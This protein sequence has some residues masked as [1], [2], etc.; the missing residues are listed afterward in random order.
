MSNLDDFLDAVEPDARIGEG[1]ATFQKIDVKVWDN[2]DKSNRAV[3]T[4][5]FAYNAKADCNLP[6]RFLTDAE[7]DTLKAEPPSAKKTAIKSAQ[8]LLRML[9]Q[10]YDV[11]SPDK[12]REGATYYVKTAKTK[13]DPLTQKGGFIRVVAFLP[14]GSVGKPAAAESHDYADGPAF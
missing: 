14:K 4:L 6:E 1:P 7:V 13:V 2:G 12:L 11:V 8:K 3:F 10:H 9:K 5:D